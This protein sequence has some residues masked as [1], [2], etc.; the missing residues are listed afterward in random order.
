MRMVMEEK[1]I[2]AS[3]MSADGIRIVLAHHEDFQNEK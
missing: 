2:N 3:R 1:G